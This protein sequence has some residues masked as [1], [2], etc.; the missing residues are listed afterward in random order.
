MRYRVRLRKIF[1]PK[2]LCV[3]QFHRLAEHFEQT[4]VHDLGFI[5]REL[6]Q[7]MIK[8]R[9]SVDLKTCA[10]GLAGLQMK[11]R[12]P[13]RTFNAEQLFVGRAFD[14]ETPAPY[15]RCLGSERRH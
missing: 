10:V 6:R 7:T 15:G 2:K 1:Y 8:L 12:H 5:V 14:V 11:S 3:S 13:E 9:A 4:E